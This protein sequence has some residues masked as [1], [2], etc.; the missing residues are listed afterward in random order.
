MEIFTILFIFLASVALAVPLGK[1][2]AKV[3]EGEKTFLDRV[4]GC[5]LHRV[6]SFFSRASKGEY[7]MERPIAR[8]EVLSPTRWTIICISSY[9]TY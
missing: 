5:C 7:F 8:Q 9:H 3:Y 2:I 1:Y 6:R 4:F